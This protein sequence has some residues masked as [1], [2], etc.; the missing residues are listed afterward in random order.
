MSIERFKILG[1]VLE[2]PIQPIHRKNR[3]NGQNWQCCLVDSSKTAPRFLIFSMAMGPDYSFELTSIETY[4]PQ[5]IGHNKFFLDNVSS[6]VSD[7]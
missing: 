6:V 7:H 2:L 1:A 4:V 5:F 3:P